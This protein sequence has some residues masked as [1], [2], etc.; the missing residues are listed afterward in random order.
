MESWVSSRSTLPASSAISWILLPWLLVMEAYHDFRFCGHWSISSTLLQ[1]SYFVSMKTYL[2]MSIFS[3]GKHGYLLVKRS[4]SNLQG[5]RS[6]L[7]N[8]YRRSGYSLTT[9]SF[10]AN[11]SFSSL[12]T[13]CSFRGAGGGYILLVSHCVILLHC[14][15]M[16]TNRQ[17][18]QQSQRVGEV[19]IVTVIF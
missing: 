1:K 2:G 5:S 18:V 4:Q 3:L 7:Q 11:S 15:T 19:I 16:V 6:F 9:Y 17:L 12:V 10:S 8:L 13:R 14:V